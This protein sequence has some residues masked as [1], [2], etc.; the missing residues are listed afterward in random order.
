MNE[1]DFERSL[2]EWMRTGRTSASAWVLESVIEHA[3]QQ[4]NRSWWARLRNAWSVGART[5]PTR[6]RHIVGLTAVAAT[7]TAVL[8]ALP[9]VT[10]VLHSHPDAAPAFAPAS[11]APAASPA[12]T[13]ASPEVVAQVGFPAGALTGSVWLEQAEGEVDHYIT[14]HPDGTLVERIAGPGSPIGIGLWKPDGQSGLTSVT[15]FA[16]AD[17]ERHVGRGLSIHRA[18]W[19]LDEAA[20]T[21][22]LTWTAT[23]EPIDGSSLPDASGRSGLVRLHRTG[24]PPEALHDLPAEP[25][26]ELTQ[27]TM[28]QGN[29]SGS[30]AVLT[31]TLDDCSMPDT[32]GYMV[33]HGDGTSFFAS[34]KGS[35]AGLWVPTGRDTIALTG[36]SQLPGLD[37]DVGWVAQLKGRVLLVGNED[38]FD[39]QLPAARRYLIAVDGKPVAPAHTDLWDDKGSVWLE[40]TDLGS[41]ITAYLT[42]GTVIAR[43]PRYGAGAGY[44]QPIDAHTIASWVGFPT[45]QRIEIRTEATIA[46]DGESMSKTSILRDTNTG[47]EEAGTATATRLHLEP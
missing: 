5:A 39:G 44:W 9:F 17:P 14:L 36:W 4:P 22:S 19:T 6:G 35:G 31:P 8:V 24:L 12:T 10:P 33:V 28:A 16:D 27:G 26:W 37:P 40:P 34:Q 7:A 47:S 18:D 30:V 38:G 29:G 23:F 42:D 45:L 41:A 32:P 43:D 2:G 20:D 46:P 21:G 13:A 11:G 3:H 1:P 15:F 25:A